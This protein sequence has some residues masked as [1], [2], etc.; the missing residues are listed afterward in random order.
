MPNLIYLVLSRS[1]VFEDKIMNI[2]IHNRLLAWV[3]CI[4]VFFPLD[5]FSFIHWIISLSFILG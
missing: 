1:I 5:N 4:V 2:S 3:D